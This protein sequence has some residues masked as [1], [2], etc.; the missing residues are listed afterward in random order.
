VHAPEYH[1]ADTVLLAIGLDEATA[2]QRL[3]EAVGEAW[4]CLSDPTGQA[5]ERQGLTVPAIV[6]T[7]RYGEIW[8]AWMGGET[9]R[10]PTSQDVAG[11]S[12]FIEIQ[13]LVC[14]Q[15]ETG[16]EGAPQR[17]RR[18]RVHLGLTDIT[19]VR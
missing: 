19:Q 15:P 1:A 9:H 3:A 17:R 10:L 16:V 14:A 6:V 2:T 8:A 12:G 18:A 5:A 4:V 7:D 13:S 11:W